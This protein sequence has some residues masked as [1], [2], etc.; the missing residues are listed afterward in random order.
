MLL[1]P[2]VVKVDEP[3]QRERRGVVKAIAPFRGSNMLARV[4]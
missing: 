1:G 3:T 4:E 2:G